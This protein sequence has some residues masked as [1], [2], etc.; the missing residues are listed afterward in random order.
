MFAKSS[1][2]LPARVEAGQIA[3]LMQIKIQ[4]FNGRPQGLTS[5]RSD[6]RVL[7]PSEIGD[8]KNDVFA[9]A[10]EVECAQQLVEWWNVR[11][12]GAVAFGSSKRR[13]R[14][15]DSLREPHECFDF[16]CQVIHVENDTGDRTVLL[17]S[18]FTTLSFNNGIDPISENPSYLYPIPKL[19]LRLTVWTNMDSNQL[20]IYVRIARGNF[21]FVRNAFTKSAIGY[22]G[23]PTC[24]EAVLHSSR[25]MR[26]TGGRWSFVER[27]SD[28]VEQIRRR[29]K[30][31]GL[32]KR[33]ANG[34]FTETPTEMP[35]TTLFKALNSTAPVPS[36]F[37][38]LARV[39]DH[40]PTQVENFVRLMCEYCGSS[41]LCKT[42]PNGGKTLGRPEFL[43]SLLL[44]SDEPDS[45]GVFMPVVV[46]GSD[47]TEFMQLQPSKNKKTLGQLRD[48]LGVLWTIG[49]GVGRPRVS[50]AKT[51]MFCVQS[52]NPVSS[53][54]LPHGGSQL[55][56]DV[57]YKL[58]GTQLLW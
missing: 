30:D 58:I 26:D 27:E 25:E 43:F 8:S 36:R 4:T 51:A 19:I 31:L 16:Y 57:R 14:T 38:F 9:D 47:A 17:V 6:V 2:E 40:L 50:D 42:C 33:R 24:I 21:I 20:P 12:S 54:S 10:A 32:E 49:E 41:G 28:E 15:L 29:L 46:S 18:D 55:S 44:A 39:V 53:K 45:I 22:D 1:C 34:T 5:F 7:Q 23:T 35:Q 56:S 52:Y 37:K 11:N 13:I 3:R 48:A